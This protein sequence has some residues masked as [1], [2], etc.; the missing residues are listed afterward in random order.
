MRRAAVLL[1]IPLLT[2]LAFGQAKKPAPSPKPPQFGHWGPSGYHLVRTIPIPGN[3]SW[4]GL[5][6]DPVRRR[7][8]VAH[9]VHVVVVNPDTGKIVGDIPNTLGVHAIALAPALNR[10]FIA[11]G[12]TNDVT[13]FNL[14]TLK[15]ITTAPTA[16]EPYAIIYDPASKR[17]FTMNRRSSTATAIDAVT[18]RPIGDIALGGQPSGAVADG[19]GRIY[20]NSESTSE[21]LE[22][23]SKNLTIMNRWPMSPCEG[24]ASLSIDAKRKLLF[25]GCRNDR[26]AIISAATGKLLAAPPGGSGAGTGCFDSVTQYAFSANADGTLTIVIEA[27]DDRF[28]VVENVQTERG[29][30]T[31]ALDPTTREV[32]LVTAN[33]QPPPAGAPPHSQPQ[34]VPGTVHVLVFARDYNYK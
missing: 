32:F 14:A 30:R 19:K 7:L 23:N 10:G 20:V 8:F 3:N 29:A 2:A 9:G 26:V 24:P 4:D 12:Q 28:N 6:F 27:G 33:F 13:I 17:I 34:I 18:A 15:V 5:A 11:D 21:E 22:I 16:D 25:A 31:I 1:A